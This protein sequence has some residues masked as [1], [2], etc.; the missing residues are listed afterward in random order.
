[1]HILMDFCW[2]IAICD[3]SQKPS[4]ILW[5]LRLV[6]CALNWLKRSYKS[7]IRPDDTRLDSWTRSLNIRRKV[8]RKMSD[9]LGSITA[10]TYSESRNVSNFPEFISPYCPE[11]QIQSSD[12]RFV[13]LRN[14]EH[15]CLYAKQTCKQ[16]LTVLTVE[17]SLLIVALLMICQNRCQVWAKIL[18][19]CHCISF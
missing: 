14:T 5:Y 4:R 6:K 15:E 10:I 2:H 12:Q 13:A 11:I 1:M 3:M 18:K 17:M 16:C 7:C 9:T 19:R 8:G